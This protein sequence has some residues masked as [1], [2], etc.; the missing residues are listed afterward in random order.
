M[1]F[2]LLPFRRLPLTS[3]PRCDASSPSRA[4]SVRFLINGGWVLLLIILIV[5]V[6][7][8]PVY[9]K[10][11]KANA[12]SDGKH[13]VKSKKSGGKNHNKKVDD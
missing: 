10:R 13:H 7:G 4:A 3:W 9:L 11:W 12:K 8:V 6:I 1:V 5:I 2:L